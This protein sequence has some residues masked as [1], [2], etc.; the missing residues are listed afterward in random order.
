MPKKQKSGLYRTKIKIGVGPD[1]KDI[2]KWISGRTKAELEAARREV[3]AYY[4]EGSGARG[5]KLFGAY[6]IEWYETRKKPFVSSSSQNAYRSMLNRNILPVFGNRNLRAIRAQEIQAFVNRF[7]GSSSSH[8]AV[9]MACITGIFRSALADQIIARDPTIGLRRPDIAAA[10]ERRALTQAERARIADVAKT[11]IHGLYLAV[12]YYLG[13]R[14]GEARGLQ[15]GDFDFTAKTVH[16]QRDIDYSK[17]GVAIGELK[18][19]S[20]NRIIPLPDELIDILM[21]HR[22]CSTPKPSEFLFTGARSA[23]ALSPGTAKRWWL[24]LMQACGLCES[25]PAE[26]SHPSH[27]DLRA[28]IRATIT[29]HALR[30]NFITMCWENGLDVFVTMKL[31]GHADYQT[32]MNIYTH[33]GQNSL[34]EAK[35]RLDRMFASQA[36]KNESCTKVAHGSQNPPHAQIKKPLKPQ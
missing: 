25:I 34:I 31:V 17:R 8:V 24:S 30:H 20:S 22:G 21:A 9:L 32:T 18:T 5:D 2:V 11:H 14:P 13:V 4:I 28:K 12:M 16:I 29:P 33:L 3:V 10:P 15:W 1:G 7:S 26:E 19:E 23:G 6:A 35:A 27:H 36:G